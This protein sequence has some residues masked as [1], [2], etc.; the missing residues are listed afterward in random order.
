MFNVTYYEQSNNAVDVKDVKVDAIQFL[1]LLE[2]CAAG[3]YIRIVT[4]DFQGKS[5]DCIK[6]L[7]SLKFV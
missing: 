6:L 3:R 7:R 5:I 1:H 2:L 4:A